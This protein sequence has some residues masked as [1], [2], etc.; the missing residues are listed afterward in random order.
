MGTLSSQ[1][2][3]KALAALGKELRAP[4]Q[5]LIVG[6]GAGVLTGELPGLW[7]TSDVDALEFRPPGEVEEVLRA[8]AVVGRQAMLP[9]NWLNID[10]GLYRHDLPEKWESRC[11]EIGRFGKLHVRALSRLDLIATKFFAHRIIDREHL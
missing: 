6:G 7:T 5:L 3:R 8:A 1:I 11:V 10:A 4:V 2:I 9:A